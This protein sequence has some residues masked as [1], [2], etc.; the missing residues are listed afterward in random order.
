MVGSYLHYFNGVFKFVWSVKS[1][2]GENLCPVS[3]IFQRNEGTHKKKAAL[4][5]LADGECFYTLFPS[6]ANSNQ[7]SNKR[8]NLKDLTLYSGFCFSRKK[9]T[10]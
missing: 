3:G 10:V 6:I 9:N 8:G 5:S 2:L 1:V 7:I 4:S